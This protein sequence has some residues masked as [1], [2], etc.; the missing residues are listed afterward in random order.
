MII[1]EYFNP[2][3]SM[4]FISGHWDKLDCPCGLFTLRIVGFSHFNAIG[5][6]SSFAFIEHAT[7][8]NVTSLLS[9]L[10]RITR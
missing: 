5:P 10:A 1:L 6:L 8:I 7:I 2:A 4:E 3:L 9:L